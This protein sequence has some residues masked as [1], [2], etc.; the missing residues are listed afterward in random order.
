MDGNPQDRSFK[1]RARPLLEILLILNGIA[2][3]VC[4][5]IH[6]GC[7]LDPSASHDLH[8]AT[9]IV[10][11]TFIVYQVARL[12]CCEHF[13]TYLR[14]HWIELLLTG[15]L[16]IELLL[17]RFF[18]A[19]FGNLTPAL[20]P[21]S[22]A[23]FFMIF[24]QA[25]LLSA[26]GLRLLRHSRR[27]SSIGLSPGLM[28]ILSFSLVILIGTALL[29]LPRATY[30]SITWLDALFTSTSAV[31]VTGLTTVDTQDTFSYIGKIILM[32]LIQVGGLGI[33][34]L[35]YFFAHYLAG[36]VSVRDRILLQD[37]ISDE[38]VGQITRT[39]M[40]IML[41]T[42]GL[43]AAGAVL[44]WISLPETFGFNHRIF[45]S[46]FHSVSAFCNAGFS[47]YS[48][49]LAYYPIRDSGM[50]QAVI[51]MLVILGGLGFPVFANLWLWCKSR[52]LRLLRPRRPVPLQHLNTHTHLA[53]ATT[54][55]LLATGTVLFHLCQYIWQ[56]GLSY[57]P[58]LWTSFF[59]SVTARTAGFNT[60]PV[61]SWSPA[62]ALVIILLMFIGGNPG[63][64]AGGIKTTTFAVGLM[65]L[66]RILREGRELECFSRR[67][68]T[69]FAN[70]A[71]A[72]T[73]LA[74][75]WIA[76]VAMALLVLHPGFSLLDTLF[77][78]VSAFGTVGL[79]RGLTPQLSPAG[80]C[81]IILTMFVG[82]ISIL[83]F[84]LAFLRRS[85]PSPLTLP[86]ARIIIG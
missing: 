60:V 77:E 33:M 55:L 13:K 23:V 19:W 64:T 5:L 57:L 43:E 28:M 30:G 31:C 18:L 25:T 61:E 37:F 70:K 42:F 53:L 27:V 78:T 44:L 81:L 58:P 71:F 69:E 9:R 36:G 86:E 16:L 49:N 11:W 47:L 51:A 45:T 59:N 48:A 38:N 85:K 21:S 12:A 80:K 82:R 7:D 39:L 72:I 17:E 63:G 65:N 66:W 35:T 29:K 41:V 40:L 15:F 50:F 76:L 67:I 83:F 4:L 1:T 2:G 73:L 14:H 8:A 84:V 68:S 6:V 46:L 20:K 10:L 32:L 34:T 26:F 22:L 79:S 3:L 74:A 54:G 56:D 75:G 62:A 52:S 24:A